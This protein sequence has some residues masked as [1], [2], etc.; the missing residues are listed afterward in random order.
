ME[1]PLT[2]LEATGP[3][4]LATMGPALSKPSTL[5]RTHD[6]INLEGTKVWTVYIETPRAVSQ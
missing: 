2:S 5:L 6:D 4:A 1:V 3:Q